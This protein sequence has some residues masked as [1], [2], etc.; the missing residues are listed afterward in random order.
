KAQAIVVLGGAL[1]QPSTIHSHSSLLHPSDRILHAFRIYRAAKAPVI[2]ISGGNGKGGPPEA[3]SMAKLLEEWGL[4]TEAILIEGRST[5]TRENA[6]FT[7]ELVQ[8]KGISRI[9]LVTSAM[10]M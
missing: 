8:P 7:H 9:I 3:Q 4:P 1:L 6:L 10:H 5:S 2:V